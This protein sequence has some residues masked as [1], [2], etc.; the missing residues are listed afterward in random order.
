MPPIQAYSALN[1]FDLRKVQATQEANSNPVQGVTNNLTPGLFNYT[2]SHPRAVDS[3]G[4]PEGTS[5]LA[6]KLDVCW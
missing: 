3:A 5:P 4:V 6:K 1:V 2:L